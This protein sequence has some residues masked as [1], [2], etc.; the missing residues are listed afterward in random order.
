MYSTQAVNCPKALVI[1]KE[2]CE[3]WQR[4]HLRCYWLAT[5]FNLASAIF[6]A[7]LEFVVRKSR[8]TVGSL[9]KAQYFHSIFM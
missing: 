1:A 8:C 4:R 3:G 2:Y 9:K 5:F 6:M 7:V